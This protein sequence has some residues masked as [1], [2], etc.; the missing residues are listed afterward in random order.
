MNTNEGGTADQEKVREHKAEPTGCCGGP[1]PVG[2]N[3]CC[4][5]DAVA[6]IA[7]ESGCGCAS[8]AVERR[9]P[10]SSCCG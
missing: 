2:T 9:R 7:G 1:A 10:K 5:D 8:P 6:K 4:A 3:A